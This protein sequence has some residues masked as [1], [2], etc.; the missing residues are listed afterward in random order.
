MSDKIMQMISGI[1]SIGAGIFVLTSSMTLTHEQLL[2]SGVVT[3]LLGV[4]LAGMAQKSWYAVFGL[5]IFGTY[6]IAQ[7]NGTLQQQYLKY[8]VGIPVLLLG[9]GL[10]VRIFVQSPKSK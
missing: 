7:A 1:V 6:Q 2:F 3:I 5:I 9:V 8:I 10:T 4:L